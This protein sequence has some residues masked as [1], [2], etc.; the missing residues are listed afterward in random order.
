M[1]GQRTRGGIPVPLIDS[2]SIDWAG[3]SLPDAWPDRLRLARPRDLLTLVRRLFGGRRRVEV[4]TGLPGGDELPEYLRQEFHH[5]PNGNYSKRI[6]AGYAHGF[7]LL[8]LGRARRA[9]NEIARRLAACRAVLDV[10]CGDGGLASA[11]VAAGVLE[12]WGLDPSPYLLREAARKHPQV[13][14]VQGLAEGTPFPDARF[15]GAGACFLFHELPPPIAD[16]ALAEL[17]RILAPGAKL[18]IV[19]PSPIQFRPKELARF[20]RRSGLSGLY[21]WLLARAVYEPFAAAWH[22]REPRAWLDAHG[23]DLCEDVTGMPLRL[24]S[25]TRRA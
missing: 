7:D 11:L 20:V 3:V 13:R 18:V 1:L 22:R 8:M 4:P 19:E 21:F 17:H 15:D 2:G 24:L 16:R 5:L 10:G 23:F 25:A 14:L 6:V 9:R 12:V